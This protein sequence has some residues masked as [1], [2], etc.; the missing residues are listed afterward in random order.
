MDELINGVTTNIEPM[1]NHDRMRLIHE[2]APG[3]PI[4]YTDREMLRQVILNLLENAVKFTD[5]GEIRI[6]ASQ[7]NGFLR[8]VVSDTGMGIK[9]EDLDHIFEEFRQ[10]GVSNGQRYAGTGLGLA[11]VK[12]FVKIMGGDIAVESEVGKGSIF[13]VTLPLDHSESA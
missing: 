3:I 11:I 6:S 5:E 7:Q 9:P 8:L 1:L 10:G 12:R 4:L 13:T 2:I